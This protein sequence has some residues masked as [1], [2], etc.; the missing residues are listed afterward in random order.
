MLIGLQ[1]FVISKKASPFFLEVLTKRQDKNKNGQERSSRLETSGSGPR[2][3]CTG[4]NIGDG[5]ALE[6][7]SPHRRDNFI[8]DT[9]KHTFLRKRENN[10]D[11]SCGI[12]GFLRGLLNCKSA[13]IS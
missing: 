13:L 6:I 8:G 9:T 4:R 11:L 1:N 7:V 2:K 12:P 3:L 10:N 5:E